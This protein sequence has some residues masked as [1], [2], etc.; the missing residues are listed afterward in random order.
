MAQGLNEEGGWVWLLTHGSG[1][2]RRRWL[3]LALDTWLRDSVKK[4]AESG[5]WQTAQ[6]LSKEGS[7]VWL[8]T[9]DVIRTSE[10]QC[11]TG[12]SWYREG[13]KAHLLSL[14]VSDS[15]NFGES[16]ESPNQRVSFTVAPHCNSR[17]CCA[18]HVEILI[19]G[20]RAVLKTLTIDTW[21]RYTSRPLT[22]LFLVC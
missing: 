9:Q 19:A 15:L 2:Q 4:V 8:L 3:S 16:N 6:G 11:R 20:G 21:S 18:S 14:L 12:L 10:T 7:W 1:N 22:Q 13:K 17:S 5:S